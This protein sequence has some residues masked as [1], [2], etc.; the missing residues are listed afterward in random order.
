MLKSLELSKEMHYVLFKFCKK[1]K[2]DFISTPYGIEEAKFLDKLGCKIFKT[3]SADLVD[4]QMHEYL[5]KKNKTVL[6]SV[7]M[8]SIEEIKD[9]V[10]I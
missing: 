1:I 4:L 10:S 7:G 3:A 6:I 9:C 2:I 8:S 5:A